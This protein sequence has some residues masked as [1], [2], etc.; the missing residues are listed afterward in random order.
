M[1]VVRIH[2][3]NIIGAGATQLFNS[4]YP[5]LVA[6]GRVHKAYVSSEVEHTA[7]LA[8][9]DCAIEVVRADRQ[10]PKAISR[11]LECTILAKRFRGEGALLV[12]GDIPLRR[13]APQVV[14]VHSSHMLKV[15]R[16]IPWSD[17]RYLVSRTVFSANA[18]YVTAFIVQSE[19]MRVNLEDSYP[20]LRG[21]VHVIPQPPPEWV[22]RSEKPEVR[23]SFSGGL[24]LFYPAVGYPHKNHA[25]LR[26][27][28]WNPALNAALKQITLTLSSDEQPGLYHKRVRFV[29]HLKQMEMI[30]NYNDADAL[31]FLSKKESY[32]FPLLEAMWLGLPIICPDLPYARWMCGPNAIYFNPDCSESL[33]AATIELHNRLS[34][35]WRPNWTD[36]LTKVP[37]NWT[38]CAQKFLKICENA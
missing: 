28:K 31:L 35:G 12:L 29:G 11:F 26:Q 16:A 32:G 36:A 6:S 8:S 33:S 7:R 15:G 13:I 10:L 18:R 2:A 27:L 3:T 30:Q 22:L 37:V 17:W 34:A 23:H 38:D 9:A 20:A 14:L 19:V 5:E 21:R 1:N 25:L 4:L 24:N